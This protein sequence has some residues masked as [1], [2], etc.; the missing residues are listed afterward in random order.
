[1]Y[2]MA[3]IVDVS[4]EHGILKV[5][6]EIPVSCSYI[7]LEAFVKEICSKLLGDDKPLAFHVVRRELTEEEAAEYIG[8][9][10]S[11]LRRCRK[12]GAV[13]GQQRGP[14]FTRDTERTIR[15]PVDEL[16]K[17]LV[18]RQRYE[19]TC[20]AQDYSDDRIHRS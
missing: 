15:Y 12:D 14:R 4:I 17:W 9:S 13:N 3:L 1:M 18:S 11:F 5:F 2:K 7:E 20:E 6:G 10:K 8:K 16:D 19:V